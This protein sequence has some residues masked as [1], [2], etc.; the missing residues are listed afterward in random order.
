MVPY[1]GGTKLLMVR[2]MTGATGNYYC[3]LHEAEDMALIGHILRPGDL[4]CDVGANVGSYTMLAA[5]HSGANVVAFEPIRSAAKNLTQNVFLSD[6][7]H[8]VDIRVQAV[9]EENRTVRM[10]DNLDTVNRVLTD[11]DSCGVEVECVVLDDCL[12]SVP[13]ALK[14]D[15][16]GFESS[17]L[18]GASKLLQKDGLWLIIIELNGA[19]EAFGESEQAIR[20]TLA[21]AG[22]VRRSYDLT[23][24]RLE[25]GGNTVSGNE[26]YVREKRLSLI[27]DR[28]TTSKPIDLGFT[29]V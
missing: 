15:V 8:L 4:F 6:L 26:I 14:I 7:S 20:G 19:G 28:T 1:A 13:L 29:L 25:T 10:T 27:E 17:V 9:G 12:D 2:G 11:Q 18:R 23:T 21:E 16:E 22:F 3:G 5:G 24:R